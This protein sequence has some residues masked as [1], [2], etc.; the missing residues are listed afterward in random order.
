MT[1]PG[2]TAYT[3][4]VALVAQPD[5][6]LAS[7]AKGPAFESRRA[8]QKKSK[9][10]DD[11]IQ[12]LLCMPCGCLARL[13]AHSPFR[14]GLARAHPRCRSLHQLSAAPSNMALF[15][16]P[17]AP[18]F[19]PAQKRSPR[20]GGT[21][22]VENNAVWPCLDRVPSAA[23]STSEPGSAL[24]GPLADGALRDADGGTARPSAVSRRV[25]LL[26]IQP[27]LCQRNQ[28]VAPCRSFLVPDRVF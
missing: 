24:N 9:G 23:R 7:G 15:Q 1:P 17:C 8:R 13:A 19:A 27:G 25:F 5:R 11:N 20:R 22:M 21:G 3:T 12:A 2:V 10:L 14:H 18:A 4:C 16:R 26:G 6:A 28:T